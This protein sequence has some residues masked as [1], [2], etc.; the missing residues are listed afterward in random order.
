MVNPYF[1]PFQSLQQ[2]IHFKHKQNKQN[3]PIIPYHHITLIPAHVATPF[4]YGNIQDDKYISHAQLDA[5]SIFYEICV[6]HPYQTTFHY[7]LRQG[8]IMNDLIITIN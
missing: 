1:N 4:P 8:M 6:P 3:K 5:F 2:S 7:F